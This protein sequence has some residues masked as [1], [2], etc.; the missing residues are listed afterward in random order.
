MTATERSA[1]VDLLVKVKG[2]HYAFGYIS[3]G[4]I[5]G[6]GKDLEDTID[7]EFYKELLEREAARLSFIEEVK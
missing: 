6:R 4:Y 3:Q 5:A 7:S 2:I 1:F